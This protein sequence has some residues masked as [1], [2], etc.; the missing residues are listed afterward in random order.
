[1]IEFICVHPSPI[2]FVFFFSVPPCLCVKF[3]DSA[4]ICYPA[5]HRNRQGFQKGKFVTMNSEDPPRPAVKLFTDGACIGNPGPGGWAFILKHPAT[6]RSKESSD[7]EHNTTNN[8]MEI[9]AVI[10]GLEALKSPST[11]DVFSD[12]QYVV[13]AINDW[14]GKWKSFGW[15]KTK[16]GKDPI[17]N[18]DLWRRLD[19]LLQSHTVKA[20]WVRGHVGHAENERCDVL[21]VAAAAKIAKTPKPPKPAVSPTVTPQPPQVDSLFS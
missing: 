5:N 10:A 8:R 2:L 14:I 9:M 4:N 18:L 19:E 6:G 13:C 21:A 1:L 17:K 15:K 12:S 7:G 3:L 11:V 16:R 20:Q